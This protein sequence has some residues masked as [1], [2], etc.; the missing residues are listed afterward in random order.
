[1]RHAARMSTGYVVRGLGVDRMPMEMDCVHLRTGIR[2]QTWSRE[3]TLS[4]KGECQ[5]GCNRSI[6]SWQLAVSLSF[7][8]PATCFMRI[9]L[10]DRRLTHPRQFGSVAI[11]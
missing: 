9:G 4:T 6:N 3:F 11:C 8:A 7:V 10:Q 2:C 1:M 5:S